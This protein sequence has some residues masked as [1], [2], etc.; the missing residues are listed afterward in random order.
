MVV[1]AVLVLVG[2]SMRRAASLQP[3]LHEPRQRS[4]RLRFLETASP[5]GDVPDPPRPG[6]GGPYPPPPT[7]TTNCRSGETVYAA[8]SKSAARKG[9]RVQVSSPAPAELLR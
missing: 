8:D 4:G 9:L 3:V 5:G 6:G 1:P 2:R 7:A